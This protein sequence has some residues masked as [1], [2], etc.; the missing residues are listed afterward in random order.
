MLKQMHSRDIT[1]LIVLLWF[2][3]VHYSA[4]FSAF[5]CV[6]FHPYSSWKFL[7]FYYACHYKLWMFPLCSCYVKLWYFFMP[8]ACYEVVSHFLL[9]ITDSTWEWLKNHVGGGQE[10]GIKLE[11]PD[12]YIKLVHYRDANIVII[13]AMGSLYSVKL[14]NCYWRVTSNL[15]P[16]AAMVT[17]K[18]C[19][20]RKLCKN[21]WISSCYCNR[22]QNLIQDLRIYARFHCRFEQE[23][24]DL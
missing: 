7:I 17:H 16:T 19:I 8:Q 12:I 15:A 23:R 2:S 6:Y 4:C 24:K 13:T 11:W 10:T 5:L 20:N 1:I 14:K 3:I 18:V 21:L 9:I 22:F